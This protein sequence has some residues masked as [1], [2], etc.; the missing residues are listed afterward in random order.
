MVGQ[1]PTTKSFQAVCLDEGHAVMLAVLLQG[2]RVLALVQHEGL[3]PGPAG[4]LDTS[5][6]S[7][8]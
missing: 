5:L 4:W 1:L 2:I 6:N 8:A 3:S 7:S